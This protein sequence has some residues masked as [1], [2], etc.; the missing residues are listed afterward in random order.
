MLK[1]R[2]FIRWVANSAG[3]WILILV[4]QV[5]PAS[6]HSGHEPFAVESTPMPETATQYL[7][8]RSEPDSRTQSMAMAPQMLRIE[9]PPLLRPAALAKPRQGALKIGDNRVL[10]SPYQKADLAQQSPWTQGTR[11]YQTALAIRSPEAVGLRLG[12]LF[13][14]LPP[15]SEIRFFSPTGVDPTVQSVSGETLLQSLAANR[16]AVAVPA[17]EDNLYWSPV[18]DGD[19]IAMAILLPSG[20]TPSDIRFSIERIAHLHKS[21]LGNSLLGGTLK[22]GESDSCERDVNCD[23]TTDPD[24]H[25]VKQGVARMVFQGPD[26][27][28]L[29]TGSLLND[30]GGTKTPYFIT[31][32]HCISTQS[33]ASSLATYWFYRSTSCGSGLLNPSNQKRSGGADLLVTFPLDQN[34]MTLLRL[35][36]TPPSGSLFLGW[37]ASAVASGTEAIG[38]HHPKGDLQK[39][40]FGQTGGF[41]HCKWN[42]GGETFGCSS[43]NS[44]GHVGID[45]NRGMTEP[46]SSGSGVFINQYRHLVGTLTGGSGGCNN[47]SDYYGRFDVGYNAGI[48]DYLS[49]VPDLAISS[50]A[51]SPSSVAPG[52]SLALSATVTN[53]GSGTA[54]ATTLSYYQSSE[55][56]ITISSTQVCTDNLPILSS[57]ASSSQSC[58][59]TAP[60]T[61]GT[62]YYG[63]CVGTVSGESNT[64]NNC[65][66]GQ[67]VTVVAP[68]LVVTKVSSPAT[69]MA[70]GKIAVSATVKNQGNAT[71]D[72]FWLGYFF[73]TDPMITI[74]DDI[75]NHWGCRIASLAPGETSTCSSDMP[76]PS[77]LAS[78]T[79]YLGAY[80]D[81]K[82][83][84]R[85]S[86]ESN[87]G[88]A[89]A[90]TTLISG[91]TPPPLPD[92]VVTMVTS[93]PSGTKGGKIAVSTTV[94]NQGKA[95]AG[96]FFLGYF[97]SK[98]STITTSGDIDNH[99]GCLI[100]SLA[101]GET[102][103]CSS[104]MPIPSTLVSD[105]YYLGAYADKDWWVTESD[106]SNNGNVAANTIAI[107]DP[108][109][110]LITHYYQSILGRAPELSGLAYYQD[111]IA[112]AQAQGDVKPAF[113]QMGY[114]FFNSP[115]Y[116]DR[117]TG[118]TDYITNLYKTFLQR[119]P[120]AGGL[121]FYLDR[122]EKGES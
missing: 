44:G 64:G 121:Q 118:N 32:N 114:D 15:D 80:A 13:E 105:T 104:D 89:A 37:S 90:N 45:Y 110:T 58:S 40:S 23:N 52:G 86:D 36:E 77:T 51:A 83:A 47:D 92:L 11:G 116:L 12:L 96:S 29:C 55:A 122:L 59:I 16:R 78:G 22:I 30:Q 109:D 9:L 54:A 111:K 85:E 70:G 61:V 5:A 43:S 1:E 7:L 24:G 69:G 35:R 120:D 8:V 74:S 93:P 106:K 33:A 97:F 46:G 112:K 60:N 79:Y 94:K 95:T 27:S 73:S 72:S 48:S 87:N 103:T 108:V 66:S 68:D 119:D 82:E 38:I 56:T 62:Y 21:I 107:S 42:S 20:S 25:D 26:G 91:S 50:F 14:A 102:S 19:E 18:V 71:A 41:W 28:Y 100:A 53:S 113:R 34:D 63:V 10:P 76:I 67:A 81:Q 3:L 31:A 84:V 39:I 4:A 88:T 6:G 57:A 117:K 99:W 17:P 75:D 101:S 115:E 65:S 2:R 98:D 49:A